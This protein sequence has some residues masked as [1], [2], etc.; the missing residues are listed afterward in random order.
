MYCVSDNSL[1]SVECHLFEVA[2]DDNIVI[3]SVNI[4]KAI[5]TF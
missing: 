2:F 3:R 5:A 4:G 1:C